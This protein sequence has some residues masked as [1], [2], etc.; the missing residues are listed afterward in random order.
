MIKPLKVLLLFSDSGGGHRSAAEALIEAWEA[1]YPGR[2][3]AEMVDYLSEYAPFP[4]NR[5]G[6]AYPWTVRNFGPLYAGIFHASDTPQR[7]R[8]IMR[9][10]YPSTR[11][12][13][14]RMLVEHPSDIIVSVHPLAN[15][16]VNW[17][18]HALGLARPYVTVVT[19]LLTVH[20]TW[21]YPR[22]RRIIVP[23]PDALARGVEYG[24]PRER[25][26][27]R[28]LPV[29]RKFNGVALAQPKE[30]VRAS[31]GLL[32]EHRAVL[33]VGGGEG[34]GPVYEMA[35]A[36]DVALADLSATTQLVVI[37]GHNAAL[38][39][40][41]HAASWRLPVRVEG[42]VK[43]MPEWMAAADV[44]VTKAGPGS[45]VEGLI[46][47][48]P[49]ILMSKVH[50]QEDGNV[51]YVVGERVG[52]WEPVPESAARRLRDWLQPGNPAVAEMSTRARA[53]VNSHAAGD[54]AGDILAIAA[55]AEERAGP[56]HE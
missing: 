18:M 44:L 45:I 27:V 37:A 23:T 22:V 11:R 49:L 55:A 38:R 15:H 8:A 24:V 25:L 32:P 10:L 40:Q 3:Q 48:L 50:G 16:I 17:S 56:R 46:S 21:Y 43:N 42:F 6:S 13:I 30:M 19:D 36:I 9:S 14:Q 35:R 26:A 39:A 34:M 20:A 33:L 41:L 53:I 5:A 2:V 28:G 7:A 47:G 54:I 1:D 12:A 52:V 31:L 51:D 4:L 29:A